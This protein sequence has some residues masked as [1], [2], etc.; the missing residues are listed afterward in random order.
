MTDALEQVQDTAPEPSIE[1][2]AREM[3][4]RP[5]EEFKGPE[6]KWVDAETF[7][8][9]GEEILP[10]LRANS[11][12][13]REALD[14]AKAEIAEMKRVFGEFK[15]YHSQ[16][17]QR[18]YQR[19]MRDLEAR[20]AEAV[21]AGDVNEVRKITKEM[22]DLSKDVRTDDQGSPY[23]GPDHAKALNQWKG[24]NPWFGSD[25]VMTA[26]ANA[27]ADELEASGV[28]GAEQ[29]AEVGKR[30]RAEFPHKFENERRKQPAAVEGA[31]TPPRKQ[32]KGWNDLPPEAKAT[33][34]KWVKQ[35]LITKEAYVKDYFA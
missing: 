18:A 24:D 27:I 4:W 23:A 21:E 22:T 33:A 34:E 5:K 35:G 20:Q 26:A 25:S 28:K 29:L 16:T 17:E 30:I 15:Q 32:G 10:I 31:V 6:E 7:V 8:K 12:K 11:K 19:A 1:D 14:A 9:R 13:D 2:N 3:G